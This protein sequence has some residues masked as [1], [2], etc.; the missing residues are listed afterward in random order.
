MPKLLTLEDG[1]KRWTCDAVAEYMKGVRSVAAGGKIALQKNSIGL[2]HG[3]RIVWSIH[4]LY[5]NDLR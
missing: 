2:W 5:G 1:L 3:W 4:S